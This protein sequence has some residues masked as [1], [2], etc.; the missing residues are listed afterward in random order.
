MVSLGSGMRCWEMRHGLPGEWDVV[1]GSEAWPPW[2]A[3]CGAEKQGTASLGSRMRRWE[4]RHGL[5]GEWDA[6]LGSEAWLPWGD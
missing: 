4:A 2:G 5:P 3:G 6:A 1:R